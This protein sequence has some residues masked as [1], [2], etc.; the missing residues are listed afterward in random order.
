M[1]ILKTENLARGFAQKRV[2]SDV[3]LELQ[4][5]TVYGLVGLNGAGKTTFIRLLL[6]LLQKDGGE[7]DVL[8]FD[9]WK[10]SP[11]FYSKL[12]VVLENDGFFGN[13]SVRDN[14]RIFASARGVS[15][16]DAQHYFERF[17]GDTE[18]FKTQKKVKFLSRGQK[19]QCGLCRAFM[20]W[21]ELCIFDEPAVS[22]DIS[23][24]E[25]L[26]SM[27]REARQRGAA[28]IISSHQLETIDDLCDRVGLLREGRI[29]ELQ[30]DTNGLQRWVIDA[31]GSDHIG[32]IIEK[33]GA[34]EVQFSD[35]YWKF[36][37]QKDSQTVPQIIKALVDEG[38]AVK[39]VRPEKNDFSDSIRTIF[40]S[41]Q[42]G[43]KA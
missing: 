36:L 17:W 15:W 10:H 34:R 37:P 16:A 24:Y 39:E 30:D 33:Y 1:N 25:H 22:L 31:Q 26:K 5:G 4:S 13:M 40:G 32:S 43:Q 21:P 12:G 35:G 14:L 8:G 7:L 19:V 28:V 18:I 20:G 29:E 9:P 6:G 11:H 42:Q 3:T 41:S 2:I 38:C 27:V 23:A